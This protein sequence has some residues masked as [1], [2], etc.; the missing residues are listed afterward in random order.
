MKKYTGLPP[1]NMDGPN[2]PPGIPPPGIRP[3]FGMPPN[4]PN[5]PPPVGMFPGP[6]NGNHEDMGP[7][8]HHGDMG[9]RGDMRED[10]RGERYRDPR[11]V[12]CLF[13]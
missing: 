8:G 10:G 11:F 2:F 1:P 9:G 5:G 3:P 7:P 4:F 12:V 6:P 13:L